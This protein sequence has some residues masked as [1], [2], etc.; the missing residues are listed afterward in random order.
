[1]RGEPFETE[2]TTRQEANR[3]QMDEESRAEM[4]GQ[5]TELETDLAANTRRLLETKPGSLETK[6][7]GELITYLKWDIAARKKAQQ[8]YS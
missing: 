1:M 4:F 7:I 5:I 6:E 3:E 2:Q 8:D